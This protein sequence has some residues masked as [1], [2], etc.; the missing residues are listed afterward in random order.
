M[1]YRCG[2]TVG[3]L[4]EAST[5]FGAEPQANYSP[6]GERNSVMDGTQ[7][8]DGLP[9]AEWY[10]GYLT[11]AEWAAAKAALCP[12]DFT[13]ECVIETTDDEGTYAVYNAVVNFPDPATLERW[14]TNYLF[15]TIGF[16]LVSEI[17]GS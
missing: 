9:R 1:P 12:G 8:F 6:G 17:G 2:L 11:F 10:F 15:I 5:L 3:T 13:G 14:L 16:I 7:P 4:V